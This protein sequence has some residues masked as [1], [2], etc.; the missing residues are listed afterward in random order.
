MNYSLKF[1]FFIIFLGGC[2]NYTVPKQ[3][4]SLFRLYQPYFKMGTAIDAKHLK[5][6]KIKNI[7][8]QQFNVFS[9][10]NDL[11]PEKIIRD[12]NQYFFNHADAL[13]QFAIQTNMKFRG[14]TL[15]WHQQ[16][17]AHFF[18]DNKGILLSKEA[19]YLKLKNHTKIL[20]DRYGDQVYA[21]DVVNEALADSEERGVFRKEKSKWFEICGEE[22]VE[23]AFK[24]TRE[25][26]A[27]AKLYYN[28][29]GLLNPIKQDR[30]I[31]MLKALLN[32][33]TPIDGVGIQAHWYIDT[34]PEKVNLLIER[35]K[36]LG[37]KIH[38]TELDVSI[39]KENESSKDETAHL[40]FDEVIEKQQ[41]KLYEDLFKVF[42]KHADVIELVS[43]WGVSDKDSW[44]NY[45]P[46]KN[47][48]NYP[49][50]YDDQ[51]QPKAVFKA[52]QKL[53]LAQKD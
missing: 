39:Y 29:Y 15:V 45:F 20:M 12:H 31:K 5:N 23:A 10:E 27:N 22:F 2:N 11:K 6:K 34:D 13:K 25:I 49:L 41:V 50:L 14:H 8:S 48:R 1:I 24:L 37:L 26:D 42:V 30:L 19:L 35:I 44:L 4:L 3:E 38:I 43:F 53:A 21:W 7:V 17:P 47:R 46:I 18:T 51:Y 36:R 28:D 33:N 32:K 9:P 16:T 52:I 40:V